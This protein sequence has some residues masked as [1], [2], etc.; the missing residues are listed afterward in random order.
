MANTLRGRVW[1]VDSTGVV[2]PD[3]IK[4]KNI[5]VGTSITIKDNRATPRE[6][7]VSVVANEESHDLQL[8]SL[9]GIQITA[10]SGTAYLYI[11]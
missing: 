6:L 7:F 2:T 4:I 11:E 3:P 1:Q 8:W 9:D 10:I 5:R